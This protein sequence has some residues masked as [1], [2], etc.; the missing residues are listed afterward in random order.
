VAEQVE[1][2]RAAE[3]ELVDLGQQQ[4]A[5]G[6]APHPHGEMPHP[7]QV[8]EVVWRIALAHRASREAA[9]HDHLQQ[10]ERRLHDEERLDAA[11]APGEHGDGRGRGGDVDRHARRG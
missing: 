8:R 7:P 6:H 2:Q 5:D 4:A 10:P 11:H 1:R 3:D 9:Q